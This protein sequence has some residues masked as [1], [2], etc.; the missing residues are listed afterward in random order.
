VTPALAARALQISAAQCRFGEVKLLT[1]T[2]YRAAGIETVAIPAIDSAKAY[3]TFVVQS[4]RRHVKTDFVLVM[5]WDGYVISPA[6]WT[7]E[8]LDCDY[9]GARW[10]PE[11]IGSDSLQRQ[12]DVGNGGFSLRSRKLMDTL[13]TLCAGLPA[14]Q[15]H[16]ED[17]VICRALRPMLEQQ[18]HVRFAPG[19]LAERF[20]FEHV[21]TAQQTF[22][23]HGVINM[24]HA[25]GAPPYSRLEFLE[26]LI[27]AHH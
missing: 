5:Q 18:A 7:A 14:D 21:I 26:P 11:H 25:I 8:F 20:S 1:S 13:A 2:G 10:L 15:L 19:A 4:L 6:A 9:I 23:F 12:Y 24:A 17:A 22:G 16:P 3:S 27:A